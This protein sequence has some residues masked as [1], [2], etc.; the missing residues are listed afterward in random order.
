MITTT[1]SSL[2]FV[3]TIFIFIT[4]RKRILLIS[5]NKF[6]KHVLKLILL[7]A[8]DSWL[9]YFPGNLYIISFVISQ[10][11]EQRKI[12]ALTTTNKSQQ[13]K[14]L[15]CVYG[16][17]LSLSQLSTFK[18]STIWLSS[19]WKIFELKLW[20]SWYLTS[21]GNFFEKFGFKT[22]RVKVRYT[23]S[24]GYC[25]LERKSLIYQVDFW[26]FSKNRSMQLGFERFLKHV[27]S[28]TWFFKVCWM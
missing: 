1:V 4:L 9:K 16:Y 17:C 18:F 7:L 8:I 5:T 13:W 28:F 6:R 26:F 15:S 11:L 27:L 24:K 25:V 21:F 2:I 20:Q 23:S 19:S 12:S 10:K 3:D 22:V 14:Q